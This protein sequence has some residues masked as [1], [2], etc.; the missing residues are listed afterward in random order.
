LYDRRCIFDYNDDGFMNFLG[1]FFTDALAVDLGS[2][3]TLIYAPDRG[4]ILNEPSVVAVNKYT[5]ELLS[6]GKQAYKLLGRE[7]HDTE[8]LHPIRNG[9]VDNFEAAQKMLAAFI[10]KVHNGQ[11]RRS[12][13]VIGVPGSA[14]TLEQRSVRD[15]ARDAGATRV[16]LVDEG[17]AAA[18][19]AG[20]NFNDERAHF[21]VDIG[22]GTTSFT[23]VSAAVVVASSSIRVAGTRM[24]EAICDFLRSRH[25][26]QLG[27]RMAEQVKKE[28]G[29]A[30]CSAA[31][32][33]EKDIQRMEIVGKRLA[34]GMAKAVE[35]RSDELCEALNPVLA[36]IIAGVRRAIE[37]SP[38]DVTADIYHNGILLTGGGSLLNGMAERVKR[39]LRLHVSVTE[40]PLTAVALGA[41]QLLM[42]QEHLRRA[43]IRQDM[44]VWQSAE[45]L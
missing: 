40:D 28:L 41:G 25:E 20:L 12:R 37:E 31:G 44:P 10:A 4:I 21:V 22:G 33:G 2:V 32:E 18:L 42:N 24:D 6:V 43:A 15:A 39:D 1:R 11:K 17:L 35:L 9:T 16:E 5:I 23:I 27:A 26:M 29:T 7:P 38:P 8:I 13:L 45:E 3:N 19:G 30:G 34:N 14:T 36:E